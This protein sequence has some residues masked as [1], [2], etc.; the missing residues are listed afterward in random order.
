[1]AVAGV[2]F[3]LTLPAVEQSRAAADRERCTDNLRSIGRGALAFAEA[4][5]QLLPCNQLSAPHGSWNT[6]LLPFIGQ[7]K[8]SH[9][10][11]PGHEW[12]AGGKSPNRG[13]AGTRVDIFQCPAT[14][15]PERRV[16]T[17]DPDAEGQSFPAAP[18]DYVG[19]AGAYYQDNRPQNLHAGAMHHR[20]LVKRLRV[21][22]IL[23]GTSQ[24]LLVVEMADK[25][26][27]WQAGQLADDRSDKPQ[28][29]A[30]SGQW[31]APNW[32]HLRSHSSDGKEAFGPCAVNCSNAAG[33]YS[34]HS[35]GANV[36]FVDGSVRF[37]KAGLSQ[38]LL[39][40]LVSIAGGELLAPDDF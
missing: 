9:A 30:L 21:S 35:G 11:N 8:L 29:P 27:S 3:C 5:Q 7:E 34:F 23:D 25:P 32:N 19:S 20:T 14:P 22:D 18:T 37:L 4:N 15:R 40:A 13:V 39:V 12:W 38:E 1:M 2:A 17:A 10:Y 33:I 6:Q 16:L 24:T 28:Q 31:A 26:N 36:L